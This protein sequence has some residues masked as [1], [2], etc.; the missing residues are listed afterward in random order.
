MLE[1]SIRKKVPGFQ[2]DI[3]FSCVRGEVTGLLGASGSGKSM[4]LR[5]LAGLEKPDEGRIRIDGKTL[6]DSNVGI[7]IPSRKRK[8]GFL[9]QHYALFPHLTVQQN[10]AMGLSLLARK[11]SLSKE[12]KTKIIQNTIDQLDLNGLADKYPKQLSGGQQQRAALGRMLLSKPQSILLD[13]PFSALDSFLR[14]RIEF[15]LRKALSAFNGYLIF[16]SHDRDE[17]FRMCNK[18]VVLNN[19]CVEA[20]GDRQ[21]VFHEPASIA[22]ARMTGCQNIAAAIPLSPKTIGVPAWGL[23][24]TTKT[25]VSPDITHVGIRA[26]FIRPPKENEHIN[27]FDFSIVEDPQAPFSRSEYLFVK[28]PAGLGGLANGKHECL[29]REQP[30]YCLGTKQNKNSCLCLPPEKLYL[31]SS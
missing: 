4:T 10:M 13:E 28:H 25:P 24:L 18:L 17:I 16:V 15:D 12:Q 30:G 1:I 26:H 11:N 7:D 31:F 21:H 6:F 8:C 5:C 22:V 3:E 20:T 9:F 19:G 2:L 27:V 29:L 23:S 14:R